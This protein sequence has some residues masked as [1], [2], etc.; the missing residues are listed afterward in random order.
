MIDFSR[1]HFELFGL[2]PRYRVDERQ[3]ELAY[4]ALQAE[5]HP[6]RH[7]AASDAQKRQALQASARVN[8]AYETLRDPVA[9]AE[10]L[11]EIRGVDATDETDTQLPVAFLTQQLERRESADEAVSA[12]DDA[13]L[14]A[15]YDDVLADAKRL[16]VDVEH[17][18]DGD[19]IVA[20]RALVRELRF[21]AKLGEDLDA[22]RALKLD[23]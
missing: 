9:R 3:L 1:N 23:Q 19:D 21:L 22:M 5:V 16:R 8:E 7:A 12:N 20:A 14:A 6:D 11:L 10:Y 15:L 13:A 4:R 2:P 18:L 17:A